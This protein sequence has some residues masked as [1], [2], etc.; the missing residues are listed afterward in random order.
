MTGDPYVMPSAFVV[1]VLLLT[2][3]RLLRTSASDHEARADRRFE[4]QGGIHQW[5]DGRVYKTC[6]CEQRDQFL[7]GTSTVERQLRLKLWIDRA[8][9]HLKN[10]FDQDQQTTGLEQ[11]PPGLHRL[12]GLRQG[13]DDVPLKDD[14]VGGTVC[15]LQ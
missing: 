5:P 7:S 6:R 9:R 4:P 8:I 11:R 1:R 3:R 12:P 15:F 13:P 10:P 2:R 14:V